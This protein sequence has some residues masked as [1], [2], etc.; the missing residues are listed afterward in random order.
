MLLSDFNVRDMYVWVQ[1]LN[2]I[3]KI[4]N[5]FLGFISSY[6]IPDEQ[7][8]DFRFYGDAKAW[9][10]SL[11]RTFGNFHVFLSEIH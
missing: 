4:C 5:C 1:T 3:T 9:R 2:G 8:V 6:S 7:A 11:R 10:F